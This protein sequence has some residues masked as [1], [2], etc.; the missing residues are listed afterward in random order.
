MSY[1][2]LFLK[3]EINFVAL[4]CFLG[5]LK[6]VKQ[7]LLDQKLVVPSLRGYCYSY[8]RNRPE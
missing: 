4:N 1:L 3:H 5:S 2:R 6:L 7:A 8:G